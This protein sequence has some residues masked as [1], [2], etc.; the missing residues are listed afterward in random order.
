[1]QGHEYE[2]HDMTSKYMN[3]NG[4]SDKD[5]INSLHELTWHATEYG[6]KTVH[7]LVNPSILHYFNIPLQ[8]SVMDV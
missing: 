5:Y 7:I 6:K 1:M 3:S 4:L 8:E 2:Q